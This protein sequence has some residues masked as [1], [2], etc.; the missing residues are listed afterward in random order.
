MLGAWTLKC[1]VLILVCIYFFRRSRKLVLP[2]DAVRIRN[3]QYISWGAW[4]FAYITLFI[5]AVTET[6]SQEDFVTCFN[7][8]VI[9]CESILPILFDTLGLC[10]YITMAGIAFM[11]KKAM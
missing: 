6:Q 10:I 4:G 1:I 8:D 5:I 11:I 7:V 3:V 2:M 9:V